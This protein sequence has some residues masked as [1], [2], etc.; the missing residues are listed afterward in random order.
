MNIVWYSHNVN[1]RGHFIHLRVSP[2][3]AV[4]QAARFAAAQQLF[5]LRAVV[6]TSIRFLQSLEINWGAY[7]CVGEAAHAQGHVVR[8]F[9]QSCKQGTQ[10]CL[11]QNAHCIFENTSCL[12]SP[13]SVLLAMCVVNNLPLGCER[14]HTASGGPCKL[15]HRALG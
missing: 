9:L 7:F 2:A 5:F 6:G 3:L 1:C 12:A 15:R 8:D 13:F 11:L 14:E 4:V 10:S